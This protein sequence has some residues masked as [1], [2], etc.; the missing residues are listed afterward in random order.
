MV[1]IYVLYDCLVLKLVMIFYYFFKYFYG[2][3]YIINNM[4]FIFIIKR[5]ILV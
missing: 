1:E 4:N 5:K 2:G 3:M